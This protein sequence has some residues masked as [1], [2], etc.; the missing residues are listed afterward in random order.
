M[1]DP[2]PLVFVAAKD[3]GNTPYNCRALLFVIIPPL[4]YPKIPLLQIISSGIVNRVV[5]LSV[6]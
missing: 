4:M 6:S 1:K 2:S 3:S 5:S